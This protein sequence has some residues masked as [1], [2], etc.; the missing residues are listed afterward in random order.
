MD[1][2]VPWIAKN[3][4]SHMSKVSK[5][6]YMFAQQ[7]SNSDDVPRACDDSHETG[8]TKQGKINAK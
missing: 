7:N 6:I 8:P 5:L 3:L 2:H 1:L 4:V